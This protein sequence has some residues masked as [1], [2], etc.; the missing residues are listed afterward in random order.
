V[1]DGKT[2]TNEDG[3]SFEW[4]TPC[5]CC[6]C[7]WTTGIQS[8]LLSLHIPHLHRWNSEIRHCNSVLC[9]VKGALLKLLYN[10]QPG[11]LRIGPGEWWRGKPSDRPTSSL[12]IQ[13]RPNHLAL[14]TTSQSA[15]LVY[16][17]LM[18]FPVVWKRS[19]AHTHHNSYNKTCTGEAKAAD[20]WELSLKGE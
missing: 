9:T 2:N 3:T 11:S 4:L 15:W 7:W 1:T 6:W 8:D 5:C 20:V 18:Q 17:Q 14:H 10:I 13:T 12:R 19:H 16:F